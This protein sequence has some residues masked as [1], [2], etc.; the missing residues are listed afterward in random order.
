MSGGPSRS[1]WSWITSLACLGA[2]LLL[3]RHWRPKLFLASLLAAA[4]L[5]C[6]VALPQYV[7]QAGLLAPWVWPVGPGEAFA[8]L[9]Q[10]NQF[11]SLTALGLVALLALQATRRA[12]DQCRP[13]ALPAL[14]P[15][16]QALLPPARR[17]APWVALALLAVG[18]ASSQ[19]RTGFLAWMAVS[20]AFA[21]FCWQRRRA[22]LGLALGAPALAVLAALALPQ[23]LA[24]VPGAAADC[25][26]LRCGV[27]GRLAQS[28]QDSRLALWSNVL[29]L[30]AQRPWTGWG[31]GELAH[32]H[33]ITL[34]PGERFSE[35]LG[36]AHNLPMHLAVELGL[37]AAAL[38]CTA[39]AVAVWR[40]RP[41]RERQAGRWGLW[42]ALGVV[43]LHSLLEHPLWFG[44]FQLAT[45]LAA[46]FLLRPRWRRWAR[47][48]APGSGQWAAR[49]GRA[50]PLA[51]V[52][53]TALL[54][55]AAALA[56]DY[57][58]VSQPFLAPP[59]RSP[60]LGPDALAQ[61]RSSRF[62]AQ[63]AAF[64]ELAL[65]PVHAGNA[66][67]VHSLAL[68]VIR[69]FPEPLVIEKLLQAAALLGRDGEWH[70][71]AERYAAAHP[72]AHARWRAERP[73][74]PGAELSGAKLPGAKLP[75]A[76]LPGADLPAGS[77]ARAL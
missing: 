50:L 41:W 39:L 62:F 65:T 49:P 36:H 1:A 37:P 8:N 28:G 17:A 13:G 35:K 6:L 60:W 18:N 40:A 11:G 59:Q 51:A 33:F 12:G 10:R 46:F 44:P 53:G 66:Q 47:R 24:L 19:S 64:A 32:A 23:L 69:R 71:Y 14:G 4:L 30:I 45:L 38:A 48:P 72:Q 21:V 67:A 52:C 26:L 76:E 42:C 56:L 61:A 77:P 68:R 57:L 54:G 73:A 55:L 16:W 22:G 15:G 29:A 7:G 75:G 27:F 25:P 31:W 70:F 3:Y 58:R 2:A 34:Y 74:V 43:G 20:A 5:S 63:E 9:R